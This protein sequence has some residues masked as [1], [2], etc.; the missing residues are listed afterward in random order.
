[1]KTDLNEPI[2]IIMPQMNN[3]EQLMNVIEYQPQT[4]QSTDSAALKLKHFLTSKKQGFYNNFEN[5]KQE[6][7]PQR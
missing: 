2:C 1:M 3:A 5:W 7:K 6:V 4:K